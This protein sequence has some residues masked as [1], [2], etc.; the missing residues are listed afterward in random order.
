MRGKNKRGNIQ[1][2]DIVLSKDKTRNSS[3]LSFEKEHVE[4]N[5]KNSR[6]EQNAESKGKGW[7]RDSRK[8]MSGRRGNEAE[9]RVRAKNRGESNEGIPEGTQAKFS[10]RDD[11]SRGRGHKRSRRGQ[12]PGHRGMAERHGR[13]RHEFLPQNDNPDRQLERPPQNWLPDPS[14]PFERGAMDEPPDKR[15][16]PSSPRPLFSEREIT[17]I[18]E[19][20]HGSPP[21]GFPHNPPRDYDGQPNPDWHEQW[22]HEGPHE[23]VRQEYFGRPFH[24]D[25]VP[26]TLQM[27]PHPDG[28]PLP[29]HKEFPSRFIPPEFNRHFAG[30]VEIPLELTLDN[31]SEILRSV[32]QPLTHIYIANSKTLVFY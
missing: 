4:E 19:R 28:V 32:S 29:P 22:R 9:K 24:D 20:R 30:G 12:P 8:N 31:E 3:A 16:R 26:M 13:H 2:N 10:R 15:A 6:R 5:R 27:F 7:E 18:R 25:V 1:R 21:R 14:K 23:G 17:E 11:W